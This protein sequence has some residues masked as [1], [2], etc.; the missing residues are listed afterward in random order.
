[1]DSLQI[2]LVLFGRNNKKSKWKVEYDYSIYKVYDLDKKL[3]AYF[4]PHYN[5][6]R[7]QKTSSKLE[8]QEEEDEDK[9][10]EEM[11]KSH[12]KVRGGNLMLPMLRLNLLDNTEGMDLDYTIK[13]LDANL[14]RAKTW[15]EWLE[16]NHKEF[17]ISGAAIYTAR[18]DRNMLSIVLGINLEMMLGEKELEIYLT[19]L[20]DKLHRDGML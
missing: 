20:L 18:E 16:L 7:H 19:P 5:S 17:G 12:D 8:E 13:A 9:I 3:A 2:L 11:N 10:I 1:M 4:F 15:K 6:L 14:Q